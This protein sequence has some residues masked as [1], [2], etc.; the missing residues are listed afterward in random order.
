MALLRPLPPEKRHPADYREDSEHAEIARILS[1]LPERHPARV[2]YASGA[3]EGAN[4]LSLSRLVASRVDLVDRLIE[5]YSA[6]AAVAHS[7]A[8]QL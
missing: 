7:R 3:W 1:D 5:V 6:H 4:T 8:P 2:A